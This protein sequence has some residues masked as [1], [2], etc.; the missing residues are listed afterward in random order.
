MIVGLRAK[1]KPKT[2]PT[3]AARRQ[4]CLFPG[5]RGLNGC[6]RHR[7]G[8]S[9]KNNC[10]KYGKVPT[11]PTPLAQTWL[12]WTRSGSLPLSCKGMQEPCGSYPHI[13]RTC[14]YCGS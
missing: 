10:P 1:E 11:R 9:E 7:S 12:R 5:R 14:H 6:P 13:L 8:L 4:T 3:H 2:C